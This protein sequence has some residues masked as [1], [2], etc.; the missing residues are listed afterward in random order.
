M[1]SCAGSECPHRPSSRRSSSRSS[2]QRP[3]AQSRAL[4]V[5]QRPGVHC[6]RRHG[7]TR[8]IVFDLVS[9]AAQVHTE[10]RP[11]SVSLGHRNGDIKL[12]VSDTIRHRARSAR[13]DLS[14]HPAGPPTRRGRVEVSGLGL[15]IVKQLVEMH[16]GRVQ[17]DS[18]GRGKGATFT[19]VLR[20]RIRSGE[21]ADILVED[22]SLGS[23]AFSSSTTA[24]RHAPSSRPSL[25]ARAPRCSRWPRLAGAVDRVRSWRPDVLLSDLSM[26]TMDGFALVREVRAM[27]PEDGGT[28][29]AVAMTSS[30]R[31]ED[32]RRAIV[33]GFQLHV[34]KPLEPAMLV[35]AIASAVQFRMHAS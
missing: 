4:G 8:A 18:A 11:R 12:T 3:S 23:F 32:A 7:A 9:N 2:P 31:I 24:T 35:A 33:E 28:V 19:V 5:A 25:K 29:P 1:S 17:C 6:R 22:G 21:A 30:P 10:R 13:R 14:A 34:H 27:P 16:G 15:A 26:P 20:P